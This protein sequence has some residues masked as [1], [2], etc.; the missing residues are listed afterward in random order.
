MSLFAGRL[1]GQ[2]AGRL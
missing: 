2:E 1:G